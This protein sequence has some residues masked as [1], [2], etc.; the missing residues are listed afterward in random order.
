MAQWE[1]LISKIKSLNKDMRFEELRKVLE[2][3]G[4]V[5]HSPKSGSSHY[6]CRKE[7]CSPITIPKHGPIKVVYV[8]M[9]K[10][11]VEAEPRN[12]NTEVAE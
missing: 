12:Q 6:T 4:Y 7:G 2:K 9:I 1:K 10:A 3:Y 8:K 11:V 5:M